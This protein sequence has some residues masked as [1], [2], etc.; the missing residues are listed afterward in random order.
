MRA[1][2]ARGR[3]R[4]KASLPANGCSSCG[5]GGHCG[6]V[7]F[8]RHRRALLSSSSAAGASSRVGVRK[9][10]MPLIKLVHP[11]MFAQHPPDVASTNSKSLKVCMRMSR[12][13]VNACVLSVSG[14]KT[15]WTAAVVACAQSS[16]IEVCCAGMYVCTVLALWCSAGSNRLVCHLPLLRSCSCTL[17]AERCV[18]SILISCLVTS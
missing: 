1:L 16:R 18:R 10:M 11:D 15:R 7:L 13:V 14:G 4:G 17:L 9:R 6:E 3:G 2:L 8:E 5:G 12:L